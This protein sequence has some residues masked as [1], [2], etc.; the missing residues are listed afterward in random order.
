MD[1]HFGRLSSKLSRVK[2]ALPE[3]VCGTPACSAA[4]TSYIPSAPRGSSLPV[5]QVLDV[6]L[7]GLGILECHAR[8]HSSHDFASLGSNG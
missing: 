6:S 3:G 5:L 7:R 2:Q 8:M 1:C 4:C